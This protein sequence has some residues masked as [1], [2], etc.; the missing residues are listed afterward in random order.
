MG[1]YQASSVCLLADTEREAKER[2][3]KKYLEK[4]KAKISPNKCVYMKHK[5]PESQKTPSRVA[6]MEKASKPTFRAMKL[7]GL[8]CEESALQ[9]LGRETD[10]MR[11][12]KTSVHGMVLSRNVKAR[13]NRVTYMMCQIVTIIAK[14]RKPEIYSRYKCF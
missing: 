13:A 4:V 7:G 1:L 6:V 2:E 10:Y 5:S 12:S 8:W 11:K 9:S 3:H 14:R